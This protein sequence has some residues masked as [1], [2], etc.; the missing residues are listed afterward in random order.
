MNSDLKGVFFDYGGVIENIAADEALFRRGVTII[1]GML[2]EMGTVLHADE[3]F[4][5]LIQGQKKYDSWYRENDNRELPNAEI[6]TSFFLKNR[7]RNK[8]VRVWAEL[9]S[10]ELSSIY[11]YYLFKRRPPGDM[12]EVLRKL[13]QNRYTLAVIS[14]TMSMT[15]IPERLKKFGVDRYMGAVVL[16]INTGIRKPRKEIFLKALEQTGLSAQRCMFVGDTLTRDIEGSK[17]AGFCKSVLIRSGVT[18]EKDSGY[19]GTVMP[20]HTI[21]TL[22]ELIDLVKR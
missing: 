20:D 12:V 7:C 18:D 14:N 19:K 3:L 9:H 2:E 15:L 21:S 22:S 11:E 5:E 17:I 10:E 4:R 1:A 8:D 13:F 16:S 6:W